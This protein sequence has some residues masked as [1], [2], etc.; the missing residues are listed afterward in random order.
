VTL[1]V[2]DDAGLTASQS[3]VVT[4]I[5]LTASGYKVKGLQKVDLSW[6]GPSG[7]S[8]D[9][10]RNGAKIASVQTTSYTDNINVKGSATYTYRVCAPAASTC[11]NDVSVS[12]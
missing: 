2:T 7:A 4:L 6:S 8:F 10:Y 12:F 11:S 3:Q 9:I 5:G 1:T